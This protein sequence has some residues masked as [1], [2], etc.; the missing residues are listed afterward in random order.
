MRSSHSFYV[1]AGAID[2]F[3]L[4][5]NAACNIRQHNVSKASGMYIIH[6]NDGRMYVGI[7][8][9][10]H[11]RVHRHTTS[12]KGALRR[13]GLGANDIARIRAVKYNGPRQAL[14]QLERATITRYGGP[15]GGRL[16]NRA[17]QCRPLTAA[18]WSYFGVRIENDVQALRVLGVGGGRPGG[19]A[20]V[21]PVQL[22]AAC[23]APVVDR[24]VVRI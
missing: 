24:G 9:N 22:A 15:E 2:G 7:S 14:R 21:L 17:W 3:I 16:L 5:H 20:P 10:M 4:V 11:N 23:A 8:N 18:R 12:R 19:V 13:D 6:L 1:Y